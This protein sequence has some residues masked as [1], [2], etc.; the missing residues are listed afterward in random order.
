MGGLGDQVK[1]FQG[2]R[3]HLGWPTKPRYI[4]DF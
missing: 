2:N 4:D 1:L 3:C